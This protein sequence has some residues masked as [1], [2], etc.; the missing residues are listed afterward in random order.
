VLLLLLLLLLIRLNCFAI[1]HA[2]GCRIRVDALLVCVCHETLPGCG[3]RDVKHS[4]SA[5]WAPSSRTGAS[6]FNLFGDDDDSIH[7]TQVLPTLLL[8]Y[9]AKANA[10]S[11]VVS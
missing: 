1:H 11:I 5:G 9:D 4:S 6:F 8:L 2:L 7:T 10:S 3:W